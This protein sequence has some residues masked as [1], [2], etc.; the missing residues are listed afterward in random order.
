MQ[1]KDFLLEKN[2]KFI[3]IGI[4]FILLFSTVFSI[5]N[6]ITTY[7]LEIKEAPT[8]HLV[9]FTNSGLK[10]IY[11]SYSLSFEIFKLS[12]ALIIL[13]T[14]VSAMII[15]LLN[16][17][18]TSKTNLSILESN[19]SNSKLN[20][21]TAKINAF[22]HQQTHKKL[23]FE[24]LNDYIAAN[25]SIHPSTINQYTLY[26]KIFTFHENTIT[27][28]NNYYELILQIN[29]YINKTN[30][31]FTIQKKEFFS[32]K[33]Y[34]KQTIEIFD[35]YGIFL[36]TC[37]RREFLDIEGEVIKLINELNYIYGDQSTLPERIYV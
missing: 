15:A 5:C 22:N 19:E 7:M 13:F 21:E 35:K 28:S 2:T 20:L 17:I 18:S 25:K 36:S 26:N 32:H 34:Q 29:N 37:F 9:S 27:L 12:A 3:L 16:Y 30:Q 11:N 33:E 24:F 8:S 10:E 14:T 31:N 6:F 23:F 4:F 1:F